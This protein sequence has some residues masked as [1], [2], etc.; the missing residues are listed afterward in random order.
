MRKLVSICALGL[1]PREYLTTM[2]EDIGIVR[3]LEKDYPGR[4]VVVIPVGGPKIPLPPGVART[5]AD[6]NIKSGTAL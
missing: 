1:L 2:G 5:A 3:M 6:P 4:T